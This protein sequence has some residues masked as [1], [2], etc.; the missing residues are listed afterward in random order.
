MSHHTFAAALRGSA[1]QLEGPCSLQVRD[2]R[3][4]E[5]TRT[6]HT[7][8]TREKR[9]VMPALANAHDHGRPLSTSSF[10]AAGKPLE[11]WLLRLAVMPSVDPYVA[12]CAA[13]GR[14]AEG[15][16]AAV[17]MHCT[18]PQGLDSL[19]DEVR[20]VAQAAQDVGIRLTFAVGMRDRNPLVYGDHGALAAQLA[21]EEQHV[22]QRYFSLPSMTPAE[23]VRQVEA[24]AAS[25]EGLALNLQFG[26]TGVQWCSDELLR[27][28]ADASAQSGR[29]VHMH[30]LETRYQREWADHHFPQG[31]VQYLADIGLLSPRLTLAHCVWA[32]PEE[33]EQIAAA[34]ATIAVNTSSN[35]HLRSGIAPV[36]NMWQT[37][38]KVAMGIDGCALD[39]DDDALREVRLNALLHAPPGFSDDATRQRMLTAATSVGRMSLGWEHP[40]LLEQGDVADW[41]TLDLDRLNGDDLMKVDSVDL[42]FARATRSH[43]D[44]VVVSGKQ[45]VERGKLMTL[46]LEQVH[47]E[48]RDMYR[49]ALHQRADLQRAWP[50]IEH[51]VAAYYRDRMGC[52]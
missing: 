41:I 46:D 15:G 37:G 45:I 24:M 50:A 26:P 39:E 17:M 18:R 3:I 6:A 10:G 44:S 33:L 9:L 22:I 32:R 23:Q 25:L 7:T 16:C 8:A 35:L 38:C 5:V 13:F 51:H 4:A 27:E 47:E 21:Q 12:A 40:A 49:H 36:G 34:G 48:L 28:I 31:I 2:G 11:T 19:V 52:C 20:K 1:F 29:R 42:L 43:L 14:A 30:L